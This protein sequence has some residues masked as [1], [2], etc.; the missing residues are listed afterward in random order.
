MSR[1]GKRHPGSPGNRIERIEPAGD[2]TY[3]LRFWMTSQEAKV[4]D[5][6]LR[7]WAEGGRV[8]KGW[9][10][11]YHNF[12]VAF[13][14]ARRGRRDLSLKMQHP[15]PAQGAIWSL[16]PA[17]DTWRVE[18]IIRGDILLDFAAVLKIGPW[19]REVETIEREIGTEVPAYPDDREKWSDHYWRVLEP[20][21]RRRFEAYRWER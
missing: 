14:A 21:Y 12:R 5:N 4:A 8:V 3:R 6:E 11:T 17:G 15:G 9:R 10:D 1:Q 16:S 7:S 18:V 2:G 13:E 20:I 19:A